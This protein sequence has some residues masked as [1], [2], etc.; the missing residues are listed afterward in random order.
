MKYLYKCPYCLYEVLIEK[1]MALSE[2]V[3]HCE[4]CEGEL[5]RVWESPSVKTSDGVKK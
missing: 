5:K 3:E 1:P 2:R 4:I